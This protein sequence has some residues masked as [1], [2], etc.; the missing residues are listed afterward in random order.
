MLIQKLRKYLDR[1]SIKYVVMS[2][3]EAY[4]AQEVAAITH[5][6]GQEMAKAVIVSVQG[7]MSMMVLPASYHINFNRLAEALG[8][9]D[10]YLATEDEFRSLFPDCEVGAMP[11]FGNLYNMDVYVAYSLTLDDEIAFNAGTH[12][13][14]VKMKYR[15]FSNLVEPKILSFTTRKDKREA[16]KVQSHGLL[17]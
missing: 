6:P 16:P 3:S 13:D 11:P 12:T 2:H 4:T 15:D 17:S 1:R 5:I 10:V 8:T 7:K 9:G 14:V